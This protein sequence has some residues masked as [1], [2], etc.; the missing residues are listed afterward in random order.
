MMDEPGVPTRS[1]VFELC[2]AS[3]VSSG[4]SQA[5]QLPVK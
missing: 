1:V 2:T 5:V 3:A 4:T